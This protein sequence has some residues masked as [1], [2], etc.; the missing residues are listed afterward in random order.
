MSGIDDF[1]G[2][3]RIER[4]IEDRLAGQ[5][6]SFEGRATLAPAGDHWLWS[7]TGQLRLGAGA[8][9]AASRRY[10]WRAKAGGIAVLF[11]DGRPF[12]SFDPKGRPEAHHWCDPD[13][14]QVA[15]D[16]SDWPEWRATWQVRGPRKDYVMQ[17]LHRR[18]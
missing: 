15:Y 6:G 11:E 4:V 9:F 1:Q 17:S 18:A 3:W 2:L 13:D 16:F 10:L 12:H 5:R 8:P 14:Y 7:E